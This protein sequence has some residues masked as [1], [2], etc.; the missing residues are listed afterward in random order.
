MKIDNK[1]RLE[2][3]IDS[4]FDSEFP[5]QKRMVRGV[6]IQ[7]TA[8]MDNTFKMDIAIGSHV[9]YASE[10]SMPY[11]IHIYFTKNENSNLTNANKVLDLRLPIIPIIWDANNQL[12]LNKFL[13][14]G[15]CKEEFIQ[16]Y[17]SI[18]KVQRDDMIDNY[19]DMLLD[20]LIS[21]L[22]MRYMDAKNYGRKQDKIIMDQIKNLH[23]ME[24]FDFELFE[25]MLNNPNRRIVHKPTKNQHYIVIVNNNQ[26]EIYNITEKQA[27]AYPYYKSMIENYPKLQEKITKLNNYIDRYVNYDI[28][29]F[30]QRTT[31]GSNSLS[32]TR[33]GGQ[34]V[35]E[36]PKNVKQL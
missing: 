30:N 33:R 35:A 8:T 2:D 7:N 26:S 25:L 17:K 20:Y 19:S 3:S 27:D 34:V 11:S 32:N 21:E 18:P 14:E 13:N 9:M 36:S 31:I 12:S 15:G 16:K 5:P 28:D 24:N 4:R 23:V 6:T 22:A 10:E 1:K 29:M